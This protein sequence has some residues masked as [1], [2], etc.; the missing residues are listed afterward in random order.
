MDDGDEL[1]GAHEYARHVELKRMLR[2]LGDVVRLEIISVLSN[3][4][5]ITVTE[6][7]QMLTLHGKR[8]SQPLV[9]WHLTNLRRVGLVRTR[10]YGRLVYCSLD[11]GRYQHCQHLLNDLV[12]GPHVAEAPARAATTGPQSLAP[13]PTNHSSTASAALAQPSLLNRT[14]RGEVEAT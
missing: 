3:R 5:E 9:S 8:I 12:A 6:L 13:S 11:I 10:R 7:A 2:A 1:A 14:P 4:A